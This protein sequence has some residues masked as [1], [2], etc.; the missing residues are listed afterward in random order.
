M[1]RTG[2]LLAATAGILISGPG[3]SAL[4]G[5]D[6]G[7]VVEID[8]LKARAP[9]SWVAEKPTS[10]LRVAQFRIPKVGSDSQDAELVIFFFEGQGGGVEDNL[11]RWKAMFLPP[12]GKTM[13]DVSRV[14]KTN[15]ANVPVT[16]LDIHGTYKFKK[17]PFAQE[18][19]LR[20]NSRM[21]A[22]YF[23]SKNGPYFL[24]L[25]GPEATVAQNKEAFESWLK[26]FK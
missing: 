9:A 6:K 25:V 23:G 16:I 10:K 17:T 13:D 11:K 8:G 1:T 4:G 18:A 19:E 20:P 5:G 3:S 21:L 2:W 14:E 22:V 7:T 15:V 12:R 26:S 24:R